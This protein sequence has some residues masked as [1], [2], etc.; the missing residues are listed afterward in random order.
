LF[1]KFKEH[2]LVDDME[3]E[4]KEEQANEVVSMKIK[5]AF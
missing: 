4:R 1:D 2:D 3:M 5:Q